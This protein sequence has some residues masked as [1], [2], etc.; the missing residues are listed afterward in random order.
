MKYIKKYEKYEKFFNNYYNIGDYILLH[1][2]DNYWPS[3]RQEL[4][5][6]I[7]HNIGKI[8]EINIYDT[9]SL[10]IQYDYFYNKFPFVL[11][12]GSVQSIKPS[13]SILGVSPNKEDLELTLSQYLKMVNNINKYNL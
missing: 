11:H 4:K 7:N 8:I 2:N 1:I 3:M 13:V 6:Y 9:D 5:D 10:H 12:S